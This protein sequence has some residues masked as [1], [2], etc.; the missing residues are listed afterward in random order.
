MN[1][2]AFF[3][4]RGFL[5]GFCPCD[6][7][8]TTAMP[9]LSFSILFYPF[10]SFSILFYPF[11]PETN[12]RSMSQHGQEVLGGMRNIKAATASTAA[13]ATLFLTLSSSAVRLQ[14]RLARSA[15]KSTR[16]PSEIPS[17]STGKEPKTVTGL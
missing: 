6:K 14:L 4:F 5:A 11:L 7:D 3:P 17:R 15:P 16:R 2:L 12:G 8:C 9:F 1:S 13:T 10:L